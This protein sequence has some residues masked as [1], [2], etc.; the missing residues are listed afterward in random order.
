MINRPVLYVGYSR[1]RNFW[2]GRISNLSGAL[3][4]GRLRLFWKIYILWI[5][6]FQKVV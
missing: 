3:H 6:S 2:I 4:R 5:F 1:S